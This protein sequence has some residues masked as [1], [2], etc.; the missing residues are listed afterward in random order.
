MT[1]LHVFIMT[2]MITVF[3]QISLLAQHGRL[4]LNP[5]EKYC[6]TTRKLTVKILLP[7]EVP[8]LCWVLEILVSIG[9][10]IELLLLIVVT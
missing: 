3:S 8:I 10:F 6:L 1:S 9:M 2:A 7:P 4:Y 5:L